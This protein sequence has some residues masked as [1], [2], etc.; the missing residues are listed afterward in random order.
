MDFIV[1][2]VITQILQPQQGVSQRGNQWY[3]QE[4]VLTYEQGQYPKSLCFRVF[5]S[6]KVQQFNIM[7]NETVTVHLNITCQQAQRGGYFNS[8]ECWKV[9]RQGM[10]QQMPMQGGYQGQQQTPMQQPMQQQP[11]QQQM[12]Q[13]QVQNPFPQQGQG[14]QMPQQQV[15]SPIPPQ[16]QQMPQGQQQPQAQ[17]QGGQTQLPFPPAAQ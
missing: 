4:Y 17:P 5:G 9:D 10:Q 6:D 8:I 13:G 12:P 16:G 3:S 7:P 2:G 11:M 1:T 14:Q 15:Q